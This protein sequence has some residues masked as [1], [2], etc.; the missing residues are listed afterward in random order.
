MLVAR[1]A[2]NNSKIKQA[3]EYLI[4][5]TKLWNQTYYKIYYNNVAY[6]PMRRGNFCEFC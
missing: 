5:G 1:F 4:S 3:L 6:I 2:H